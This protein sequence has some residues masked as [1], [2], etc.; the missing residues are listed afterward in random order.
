MDHLEEIYNNAKIKPTILHLQKFSPEI[1]RYCLENGIIFQYFGIPNLIN[2][3]QNIII[4]GIAQTHNVSVKQVLIKL[5]AE[6]GMQP[7]PV[8][9]HRD[10]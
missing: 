6:L 9:I 1:L 4:T 10:I 8:V 7:L 5:L 2:A 3:S